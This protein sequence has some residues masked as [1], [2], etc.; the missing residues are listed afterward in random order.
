MI[1]LTTVPQT[2]YR[3]LAELKIDIEYWRRYTPIEVE[4]LFPSTKK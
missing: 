3:N 2:N 1:H 4:R